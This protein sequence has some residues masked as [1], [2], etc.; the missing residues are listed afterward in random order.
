M[1]N[2]LYIFLISLLNLS[3]SLINS[4]PILYS[5]TSTYISSGFQLLPPFDR[6]IT[7]G[8]LL[9]LFSLNGLTFLL[10]PLFQSFIF[11][12]VLYFIIEVTLGEH[13]KI[14]RLFVL[15]IILSV[16][17]GFNWSINQL[18]PDF[19]TPI[20]LLAIFMLFIKGHT[21]N[22]QAVLYCL[23]FIS[24][25]SHISNLFVYFISLI[26]LLLFFKSKKDAFDFKEIK[27]KAITSFF[28]LG[29]A[30][31]IMMSAISKSR[32]IFFAGN[33]AQKGILQELLKD[34]CSSNNFKF[35]L[36]KDS[37]P[38]SFE[39]FVWN[40][41]SPLYRMGGWKEARSELKTLSKIS[42]SESKYLKMHFIEGWK[43]F[44]QQ[45]T[46]F[47]I[48]EGNGVFLENTLLIE[49]IRNHIK[50]DR[51]LC[52]SSLQNT[53][54]FSGIECLNKFYQ[55]TTCLSLVLF[56]IMFTRYHKTLSLEIKLLTLISCLVLISSSLLVA[57]TSEVSNRHGC[58][59]MWLFML[60]NFL[61]IH[62]Q[63][64][65]K[66]RAQIKK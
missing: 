5:D 11:T 55:L 28:I 31:L 24:A 47:D 36:Y 13:K 33:M 34:E 21:K 54:G 29:I 59:L 65:F 2:K 22:R 60:V 37:I 12:L 38:K 66:L 9:R 58:K 6:P 25:A 56:L 45:L 14:Q 16:F 30:Y 20:G 17:T 15:T 40:T 23:M 63:W 10:V 4:Y 61:I 43:N 53:K 51:T 49:R 18:L 62:Q 19:L 3:F 48:G 39:Y 7:Y 8:I 44:T 52:L 41:N 50:L 42:V 1:K 46:S 32:N 27:I 35:C 57:F 26:F 64:P